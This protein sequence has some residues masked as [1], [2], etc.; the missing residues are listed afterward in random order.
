MN[1]DNLHVIIRAQMPWVVI[2][3]QV[4][5]KHGQTML[6]EKSE[7]ANKSISDSDAWGSDDIL[8]Q[9]RR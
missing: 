4:I 6:I 5:N 7:L 1:N 8:E 3:Y 9:S 2:G